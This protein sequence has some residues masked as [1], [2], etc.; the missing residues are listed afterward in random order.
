MSTL[1]ELFAPKLVRRGYDGVPTPATLKRMAGELGLDSLRYLTVP[2]LGRCLEIDN[3][4]LCLGCV[5]GK[6]PTPWGNRLIAKARR[7]RNAGRT[8][9]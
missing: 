2:D 4:H 9:E 1:D 8:Y 7:G 5:T 6:Y 3:T